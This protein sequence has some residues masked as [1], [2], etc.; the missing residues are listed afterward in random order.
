MP[1]DKGVVDA[2]LRLR[3]AGQPSKGP[4][5]IHQPVPAGQDFMAVALM[6]HVEHQPVPASVKD[7]VKGHRQFHRPQI[8]GQMPSGA[9]YHIQQ[10]GPQAG[11]EGFRFRIADVMQVRN[12]IEFYQGAP[13]GAAGYSP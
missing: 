10:P 12:L 11:A 5:G 6:S 1:G 13:P 3:I 9:G 2:L 7:P 4:Q 8:G